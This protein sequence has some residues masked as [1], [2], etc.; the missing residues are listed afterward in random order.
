M[1]KRKIVSINNIASD[2]TTS[3]NQ[4]RRSTIEG[5]STSTTGTK[6]ISD[7][8]D[9]CESD[10]ANNDDDSKDDDV[11]VIAT[12]STRSMNSATTKQGDSKSRKRLKL[13]ES[14][15]V[16]TPASIK[17]KP[18]IY[19]IF[20]D[21]DGVLVDFEKGVLNLFN[22]NTSI[23]S[24]P[25][26][27]LWSRIS[28]SKDFFSNLPWTK[29]G[30]ELWKTLVQ[31]I[32]TFDKLCILTGCPRNQKS[33]YQKFDWCKNHLDIRNDNG[34]GN[35]SS[36]SN[37]NTG[38]STSTNTSSSSSSS[39]VNASATS[40]SF[41]FRFLHVD[42]AAKKSRH[43]I[44]IDKNNI[45]GMKSISSMFQKQ[46]QARP[47]ITSSSSSSTQQ[48]HKHKQ[49]QQR[50]QKIEIITCWSKNKHCESKNNHVL[51]D[52]RISLKD[53]WLKN[54]GIF[55]HHVNTKDT[56]QQ[57]ISRGIITNSSL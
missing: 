46:K 44:V 29:D 35:A 28:S 30:M 1:S 39:S 18:K 21:L 55:I 4:G 16:S 52:D 5:L 8:I 24:I 41:K 26:N 3:S 14:L 54:G 38:T 22:K 57:L 53:A 47:K 50:D 56:I 7:V 10:D 13:S 45:S 36:S 11:I 20:C 2:E 40:S 19:K 49:Q 23:D 15:L 12:T 33:R 37:R 42:K 17:R 25:P 32:D 43:E 9:L 51:I 27:V 6:D 48:T 34:N 31:N